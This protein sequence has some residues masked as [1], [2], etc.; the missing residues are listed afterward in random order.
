MFDFNTDNNAF[1]TTATVASNKA[2]AHAFMERLS[3]D[4][5]RTADTGP[6]GIAHRKRQFVTPQGGQRKQAGD[7]ES[8]IGC[9][10]RRHLY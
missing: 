3:R 2:L 5:E 8:F 9:G 10:Y 7:Q 1:D 4:D 6:D